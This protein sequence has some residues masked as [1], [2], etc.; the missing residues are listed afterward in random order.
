[1]HTP[2]LYNIYYNKYNKYIDSL[3]IKNRIQHTTFNSYLQKIIYRSQ[4]N[5]ISAQLTINC[6]CLINI[7]YDLT[8]NC[9]IILKYFVMLDNCTEI[10]CIDY[11]PKVFISYKFV[12]LTINLGLFWILN[13][14]A[15][16]FWNFEIKKTILKVMKILCIFH[17]KWI[18]LYKEINI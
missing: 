9:Y 12:S 6:I 10:K 11:L 3:W 4:N 1:M 17:K 8:L 14:N 5:I 13:L 15:F 16:T 2:I 18:K 7:K